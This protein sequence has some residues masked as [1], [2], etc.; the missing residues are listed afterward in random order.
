[1]SKLVQ[2]ASLALAVSLALGGIANA[3]GTLDAAELKAQT[4]TNKAS[5][6]FT[7][8]KS[9]CISK[10]LAAQ[11]KAALPLAD[12]LAP[13]YANPAVAACIAAVEGKFTA[14]A[15]KAGGAAN[16]SCPE[17]YAGG[18]CTAAANARTA[19]IE[20][21]IDPFG[22]I[23]SCAAAPSA[24]EFKCET[25]V[26]KILSKFVGARGKCYDK[27]EANQFKGATNGSCLPPAADT[28]TVACLS[29][30]AKGT[31]I[32]TAAAIDKACFT[33][34]TAPA[35]YAGGGLPSGAAWATL[36]AVAIDGNVPNTYCGSASGAFLN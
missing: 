9:G 35:C 18:D 25:A 15:I 4:S 2:G 22:G 8:A 19:N 32:K 21:Q 36:V 30:P 3:A 13:G 16:V 29:D 33:P 5:S 23:V 31:E 20:S 12:C 1:M 24:A 26:A 14:A 27:C 11:L 7:A 28:A 34:G 17:C 6:K 10:C